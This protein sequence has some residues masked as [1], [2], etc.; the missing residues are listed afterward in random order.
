VEHEPW[1]NPPRAVG[2][3]NP[4]WKGGKQIVECIVCGTSVERYPSNIGNVTVCSEPCRAS[5]L[6]KSFAGPG[7]PNWKGGGNADYGTGWNEI[8][9]QALERDGHQCVVCKTT[10]EELGRNPDV[11]H[12]I[13]VRE[14]IETDGFS[15]EDAH[16]LDNVISLCISCHR[17]AEFDKI[18]PEELRDRIGAPDIQLE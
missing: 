1:R 8:R 11:H 7:H 12:I 2:S 17:K 5:W 13:P 9:R 18:P 14:F 6:S 16:F 10:R 3:A 15:R 4:R